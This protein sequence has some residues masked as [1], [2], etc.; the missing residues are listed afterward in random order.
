MYGLLLD[1]SNAFDRVNYFKL[2]NVLLDRGVYPMYCRLLLNMYLQQKL[3]IRWNATFSEYFTIC[4]DVKQG[5][6]ISP[7]LFCIYIGGLLIEL[8]NS[9]VGCYMGSVFAGAFGY[10]N[11]DLKLLTPT[12]RA[13]SKMVII[14]EQYAA[15]YD[16]MFN[17]KKSKVI[18]YSC[19]AKK[20]T[21]SQYY[22]KW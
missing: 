3:T 1:A 5:G 10:A 20:A 14:C 21:Q 18:I 12:I 16:V 19:S 15:R 7:V 4:N 13:M 17:A 9:G 6:F 8:E 22:S 2:F 11:D